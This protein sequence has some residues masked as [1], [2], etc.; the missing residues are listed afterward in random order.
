MHRFKTRDDHKN[1]QHLYCR[2]IWILCWI[3][4]LPFLR[5]LQELIKSLDLCVVGGASASSEKSPKTKQKWDHLGKAPTRP[6]IKVQ[7][8]IKGE[9]HWYIHAI[10]CLDL[11][12]LWELKQCR[13][14]YTLRITKLM[15]KVYATLNPDTFFKNQCTFL[16]RFQ[17]RDPAPNSPQQQWW[18]CASAGHLLLAPLMFL[19]GQQTG[20]AFFEFGIIGNCYGRSAVRESQKYK[21]KRVA[22]L[23]CRTAQS[24]SGGNPA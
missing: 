11:P 23:V 21:C 16:P 24:S 15:L 3:F 22:Y 18:W 4:H 12:G 6:W 14:S 10:L 17:F 9:S 13:F 8:A 20:S 19:K 2:L 7:K 5:E 1:W